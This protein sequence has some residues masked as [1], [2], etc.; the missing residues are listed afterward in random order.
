MKNKR[1]IALSGV[2]GKLKGRS[3]SLSED[4]VSTNELVASPPEMSRS[5]SLNETG[6][7]K[8]ISK[9]KQFSLRSKRQSA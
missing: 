5:I 9:R 7:M 6:Q 8:A 4:K 1:S 2:L 3:A